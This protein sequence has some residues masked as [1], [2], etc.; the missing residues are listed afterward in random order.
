VAVGRDYRRE[1]L[2]MGGSRDG[3]EHLRAFLGR[4]PSDETFLRLLG[5][6]K[7][8]AGGAS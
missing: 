3:M 2:E 6:E 4:E 1:V 7:A 8:T 5:I